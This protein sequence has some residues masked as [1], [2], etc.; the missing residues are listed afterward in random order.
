MLAS[1][2]VATTLTLA[3]VAACGADS[4]PEADLS[5]G[6]EATQQ[7]TDRTATAIIENAQRATSPADSEPVPTPTLTNP[8]AT[9]AA[10]AVA[11]ATAVA[12]SPT[13]APRES[14]SSSSAPARDFDVVTLLAPDAIPAI[15]NPG[16]YESPEEAA[17]AYEDDML[18]LGIEIHGDA[19]AYSV[20]FL[21][22]HE[23]VNDYVGG[24]PVAVTW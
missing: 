12:P 14:S 7:A 20:P 22:R 18:V 2:A 17:D 1:L 24:E 13:T 21:S 6:N 9:E 8:A 16:F 4:E 5:P 15:S 10:E 23:I 19:R 3:V 11:A